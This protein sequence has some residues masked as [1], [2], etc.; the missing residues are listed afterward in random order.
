MRKQLRRRY[1]ARGELMVA[2][3]LRHGQMHAALPRRDDEA[4]KER[5]AAGLGIGRDRRRLKVHG[6]GH[7]RHH[8]I[9]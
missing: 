8:L 6:L 2:D 4:A 5:R 1:L 9:G 7:A 3:Q